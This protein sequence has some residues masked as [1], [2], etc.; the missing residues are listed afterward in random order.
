MQPPSPAL[1]PFPSFTQKGSR[2]PWLVAIIGFLYYAWLGIG[3]VKVIPILAKLYDGLGVELPFPTRVLLST[4]FW[5]LPTLFWGAAVLTIVK[6]WV[7][8]HGLQLRAANW[9]LIFVGA[10]LPPSV[11]LV[12]YLPLFSL[13]GKLQGH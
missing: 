8:F 6:Q 1:F 2:V 10:I 9:L 3:F 5:S 12:V 4:Y 7:E 11:I 13:I